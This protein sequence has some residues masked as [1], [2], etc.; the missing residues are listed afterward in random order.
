MDTAFSLHVYDALQQLVGQYDFAQL[1]ISDKIGSVPREVVIPNV[2]L[3]VLESSSET[4]AWLSQ[5]G[6]GDKASTLEKSWYAVTGAFIAV[7]VFLYVFFAFLVPMGAIVFADMV[8]DR[9][10]QIT[11]QQTLSILDNHMLEV[12]EIE[13]DKQQQLLEEFDVVISQLQDTHHRFNIQFRS[14][15]AMGANAF[16]LPDGTIVITD[17]FI[18]LVDSDVD[19][20]IAILLHEIGHVEN[21]HSMR[22]IAETLATALAVDFFIGD[23]GALVE[24]FAGVTNTIAQNQFSQELEWEADNYA[25][26]QLEHLGRNPEDFAAAMERLAASSSSEAGTLEKFLSSHPGIHERIMNARGN[27]NQE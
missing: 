7:P 27:N 3:L 24:F 26:A 25:L 5:Y 17:E 19:L 18:K 12:S 14:S 20:I 11:S 22:L 21:K 1:K 10:V 16:A 6:K 2:G 23:L 15:E 13:L 9:A 8:P 4:D